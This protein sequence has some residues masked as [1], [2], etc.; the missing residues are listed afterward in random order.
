MNWEIFQN[1]IESF[2]K[3]IQYKIDSLETDVW[4][5]KD[6]V[7]VLVHGGNY[8]SNIESLYGVPGNVTDYTYTELSTF[9]TVNDSL[10]MPTLKEAMKLTKNKIF[11]DLEI[12]DPRVDLVFPYIIKLIEKYDFFNQISL[13]S[14]HH[15]YY[16]KIME[17]NKKYDKNLIFGFLYHVN[18]SNY[19]FT[20]N[21]SFLGIYHKNITRGMCKKVHSNGMAILAWFGMFAKE[22]KIYL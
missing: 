2:Q 6:K 5:T 1:T 12:K 13:S 18:E 20:K 9:R 7:L 14:F 16:Y 22:K 21:G 10:K 11:L 4:L 17:Y 19:D 15:D 3:A 8:D